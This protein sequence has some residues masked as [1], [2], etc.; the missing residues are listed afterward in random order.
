MF[1]WKPHDKIYSHGSGISGDDWLGRAGVFYKVLT[2]DAPGARVE[3]ICPA[4]VDEQDMG[5][6]VEFGY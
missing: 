1:S 6:F 5:I 3:E 2:N 4:D